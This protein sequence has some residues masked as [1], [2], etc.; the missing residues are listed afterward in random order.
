MFTFFSPLVIVKL[1][2]WMCVNME[3]ASESL[4]FRNFE[5]LVLDILQAHTEQ[6]VTH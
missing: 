1:G 6:T 3:S 5:K 4:G 2:S